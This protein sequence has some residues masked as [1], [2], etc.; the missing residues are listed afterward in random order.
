MVL[1]AVI[2]GPS[3]DD[4]QEQIAHAL[5]YADMLEF[6]ADCYNF[7]DFKINFTI[8]FI[9][10][11]RSVEEVGYYNGSEDLRYKEILQLLALKPNYIDLE[12]TTDLNFIQK[13]KIHHPLVKII[14]SYHDFVQTPENLNEILNDMKKKP[15]DLYKIAC[16]ANSTLDA[17]RM[18]KFVK[19]FP[20]N[21]IGLCMGEYGTITRIINTWTY[22]CINEKSASAEGQLTL[23]ILNDNYHFKSL[24]KDTAIY[25]LIGNPVDQSISHITHNRFFRAEKLNAVY[26]KMLIKEEELNSFFKEIRSLNFKGL[27]VTMPLKQAVIPYLD[28]I[29]Q[30]AFLISAVNTIVIKEDQLIGFN[31]DS[32][33]ALLALENITPVKNKKIL[34]IGAGG[35]CRAIA[36]ES[37]QKGADC[38]ILNRNLEKALKIAKDF[39]CHA[40][41]LDKIENYL[42]YDILINCTPMEMPFDSLYIKEET[43]VMDIRLKRT[44]L[45]DEAIL[46]KCIPIEGY[47][48]F[49]YQ[50]LGQFKLWFES[51][52]CA[53]EQELTHLKEHFKL[54]L[55][56]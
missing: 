32:S 3:N 29:D 10:T 56:N 45:L 28:E 37:I 44:M 40:D 39:Q 21:V 48:M 53:S 51:F 54:N 46:K 7:L 31:T 6:R 17:L 34:I 24:N 43:I 11:L 47:E 52:T 55:R 20:E 15:A 42:F 1:C 16:K 14:L 30:K 38:T 13:I 5:K 36:Y 50:A 8:P 19:E 23:E 25:G 35:A 22:A 9:I 18:L 4:V 2:T 27:S 26:V 49:F 33:G 12:H 41:S